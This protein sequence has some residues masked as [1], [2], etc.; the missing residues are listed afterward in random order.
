MFDLL[1]KTHLL[2]GCQNRE[3]YI[4]FFSSVGKIGVH[5]FFKACNYQNIVGHKMCCFFTTTAHGETNKSGKSPWLVFFYYQRNKQFLEP[6][7]AGD[8]STALLHK[9]GFMGCSELAWGLILMFWSHKVGSRDITAVTYATGQTPA[10]SSVNSWPY[11]RAETVGRQAA[12]SI[13]SYFM[14]F[15][16]D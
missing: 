8:P 16:I 11:C 9:A 14:T 2:N 13:D 5:G 7:E 1:Q 3:N 12:Q 4:T 6:R 15:F 10:S